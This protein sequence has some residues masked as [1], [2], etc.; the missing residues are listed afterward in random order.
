LS[1]RIIRD[2]E[3]ERRTGYSRSQRWRM[4]KA[5]RFPVRVQLNPNVGAQGG[6][7]WFEDEVDAWIHDRVRGVSQPLPIKRHNAEAAP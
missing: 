3:V 7:G 2:P 6:V 4:E 5:G 1:R